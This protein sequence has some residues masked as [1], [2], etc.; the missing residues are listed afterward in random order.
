VKIYNFQFTIYK[1]GMT[2]LFIVFCFL[3][4]EASIARA[5]SVDILWQGETYTPPF[6]QGRSLW[7]N[8]SRITLFALPQGLGNPANLNYKWTKN[9]TVLGNFNGVGKNALAF[10][11]SILSRPQTIKVDIVS[12]QNTVLASASVYVAPESPTLDVYEDN[13]LY[14][15]MFHR[16]VDQEYQFRDKETKFAAFPLFFSVSDRVNDKIDYKWSTNSGDTETKNSV[17]YRA[18]DDAAGTSQIQISA[19]NHEQILQS[20]NKNFLIKFGK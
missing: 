16:A 7:S 17:T 2:L 4:L 1:K 8:Q 14:G 10:N 13:P 3:F 11:D 15:F 6:Y 9:G 12:G 5:Q 19:M 18:P 20:F